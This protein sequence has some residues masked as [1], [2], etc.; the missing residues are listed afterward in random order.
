MMEK[1]IKIAV[2]GMGYVGLSNAVLLARKN[3]VCMLDVLP[4]KVKLINS[5]QSPVAD[6]ELES[7]LSGENLMLSATTDARTAY[8]DADFVIIAT[9]T[10]YD[11]EKDYFDTSSVLDLVCG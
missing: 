6:Q 5:G 8:Q 7:C 9:P 10:D 11:R 4:E 2:A 3:T 1:Q